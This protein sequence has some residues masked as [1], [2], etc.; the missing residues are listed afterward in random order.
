MNSI[1]LFAPA[2]VNLFLRVLNKRKDGYHGLYTLFERINL[3]DEIRITRIPFGIDIK[4]DKFITRDP[5]S[6]LAYKAAESILKAGRVKGGVRI[7]IKKRIPIAGGLGGGSSDAATVLIGINRLYHLGI[8]KHRL[9]RLGA[10]LG[11][12]VAF[13]V[14][15][16]PFAIGRG[17][18]DLLDILNLKV[19]L[20]HILVNPVFGVDK[21]C[22]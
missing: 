13:F 10:R 11:A 8:S 15:E 18:G 5:R 20:W 21:G 3:T 17:K 14:L 9:L 16:A 2:K 19:K 6:N 1:K 12:D 4:S 22:I 7:D